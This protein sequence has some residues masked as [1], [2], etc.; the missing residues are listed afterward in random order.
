MSQPGKMPDGQTPALRAK[1]PLPRLAEQRLE[2][3]PEHFRQ[4]YEAE[5]GGI[6][7]PGAL[8]NEAARDHDEGERWGA[9]IS[10]VV[11]G[12]ERGGRQWTLARKK[13]SLQRVL[14]GSK[15]SG[16]RLHQRLGQLISSWESDTLDAAPL[17]DL[18]PDSAALAS[19]STATAATAASAPP[20]PVA[21]PMARPS[22]DAVTWDG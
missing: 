20:S 16:T 18:G 8:P 21:A 5:A 4:A 13:D 2:P 1:A 3:T 11:R 19:E 9:L 22:T 14:E 15:G 12:A 10:R 7:Q 17:E 6:V